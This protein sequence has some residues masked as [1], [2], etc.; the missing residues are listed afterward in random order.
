MV[1]RWPSGAPLTLA[2]DADTPKLFDANDF[3]YHADD[4]DGLHCPVASHVRRSNP[5]DSL[6]PKPG[7]AKSYELNKRHRL[8]RRGRAYGPPMSIDEAL[9]GGDGEERG[10]FFACVVGNISRQFEF[11]QHTWVNNGHFGG[12]YGE[13]DPVV[14]IPGEGG[15]TFSIPGSPVRERLTGLPAFVTVRGGGYFFMPGIRAI[16]YLAALG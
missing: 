6:D 2:P 8:L 4:P 9:A 13:I 16:R 12:A 11:V 1:G 10:L 7:T 3:G 14:A 5:R 15:A